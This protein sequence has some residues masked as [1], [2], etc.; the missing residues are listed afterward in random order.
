M[1]QI[2]AD[3]KYTAEHEWIKVLDDGTALIGVTD[4]AQSSLGD[5]TFV[6]MP[7]LDDSFEPGET[8]GVVESVKAA[9]D[10]FMPIAGTVIETNSDLDNAP[11]LINESPY[12]KAW[13]IKINVTD[14]SSLDA[15]LDAQAYTEIIG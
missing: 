6:E 5:V 7:D 15:L 1:S 12:E 2:P 11:E 8:F 13:I 9:S 3:L 10:L 4:Y 14:P